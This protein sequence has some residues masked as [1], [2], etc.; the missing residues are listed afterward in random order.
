MSTAPSELRLRRA[1]RVLEV[2]WA[3]GTH[4]SLPLEYL[5]TH[6]PSAEVQGHGP[7]QQILVAGK[8]AVGVSAIEPVGQYGVL[9]RFDDGH[10]TGIFS[11]DTLA[12]L[13]R[14]HAGNWQT[15]LAALEKAGLGRD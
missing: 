7:G 13:G 14:D 9:L 11:W 12:R 15:Y 10:D 1:E 4:Y 3:D 8:R 5:R 2:S 6:S